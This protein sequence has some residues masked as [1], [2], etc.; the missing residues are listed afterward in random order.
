MLRF[1]AVINGRMYLSFRPLRVAEAMVFDERVIYTGDNDGALKLAQDL[2]AEVVDLEGRTVMPGFV[3]CHM[4]LD[5]LGMAMEMIDLR[6]TKS[7]EELKEKVRRAYKDGGGGWILGHGWD[8]EVMGRWP[9]RRDL[10]EVAPDRPV[11]LSRVCLHAAVLNTLAME[12][13]GLMDSDLPGVVRENGEPTGVVKEEAFEVAREGMKANLTVEDYGRFV[14]NGAKKAASLGVTSVGFVSVEEK[15]LKALMRLRKELPVRVFAYLD[16]GRRQVQGESMYADFSTL[17]A[18]ERLGLGRFSSGRVS[19]LGIKVLADGSFGARTAWLSGR[20]ADADTSGYPNV[21][22]ETLH[23]IA[24]RTDKLGLQMAVHAIGDAAVDMVLNAYEGLGGGHRIEH[25]SL[26]R[27]DQLERAR[28]LGVR[29]AVQPHFIFTDWWVVERVGEERAR[30][31]YPFRSMM[32]MGLDVGFSTDCPVEPLNPWETVYAAVTR[33]RYDGVPLFE[34]TAGET[35][36]VEEALHAY[37]E[38]SARVMGVDDRLGTLEVGKSADFV[39]LD[40]DPLSVK[41]GELRNLKVVETYVGGEMVF[42]ELNE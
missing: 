9:T 41:E 33:G 27:R 31:V 35:L 29:F 2:G 39:V 38:G 14:L 23:E 13:T 30:W 22:P 20:Y 8:Q 24:G 28:R 26:I 16:P 7:V 6:G 4:H 10:D 15:A 42:S 18:L 12:L 25:A 32:E 34:F 40:G 19:V 5:E 17:D 36:S 21:D 3:D 1:K 11:M 37:T